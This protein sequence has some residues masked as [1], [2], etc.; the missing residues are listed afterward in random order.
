[1]NTIPKLT[2]IPGLTP[3]TSRFLDALKAKGFK[4]DIL[5]DYASRLVN[6]TDNSVYQILPQAVVA[7]KSSS[8]VELLTS[9]LA[10]KEHRNVTV[11]PRGGG[12]G[13]NG[14]SLTPGIIV[15]LSRHMYR[16][17]ELDKE[18]GWVRVQPGV[19]LDQLNAYLKPHGL[20][21]APSVSPSSRATL[22]GMIATDACGKGSRVYGKT[23]G[24][25]VELTLC[26]PDGSTWVSHELS[27]DELAVQKART[28]RIGDVL[29]VVDDIVT[30]KKELIEKQF[31][32][33]PRF[34]TGYNLAHV[35][36]ENSPFTLNPIVSGAE[37]SLAFVTEAKLRVLPIP[38][39]KSLIAIR[40]AAF[41]DALRAA[42]VL[43]AADPGAIETVDDTIVQLAQQDAIW[44]K[45]EHLLKD[46]G[47]I[48]TAA[49]NLVEFSGTNLDEVTSKMNALVKVL[50]EQLGKPGEAI[51]YTVAPTPTDIA[52]L[53]EL[54]KKGVGLLGNAP[55]ERRPIAFVEDTAVH[56]KD[57]AAFIREFRAILD[58][59]GLTYGMFGHVD[60]GCLHVRPALNTRDV[61]DEKLLREVSDKV[62]AL[63]RRY[64][65]VMWSEHGKGFRSEYSPQFFG[66]EL[67]EDLCK[68]KRAF[69]PHN[70]MNPGKIAVPAGSDAKLVSVDALKRGEFDRM[71]SPKSL[72]RYAT[73][74]NCNG[75]GACFDYAADSV[76]CPS[77]KVTRDRIHS[78]KGRAGVMR[79][80]LRQL[81]EEGFDAAAQ[82][83]GKGDN[84]GLP[85][86]PPSP[87]GK[88]LAIVD[89]TYDFSHEVYA[90]M[91]GCLSCKACA[92]QCPVKVDVPEFK[93][94]FLHLYHKRY[95][96]PA[97]DLFAAALETVVVWMAW[98]PRLV[99]AI[100]SWGWFKSILE[101]VVG[102][103]DAPKL[104]KVN[105]KAGLT[106]RNAPAFDFE[107]LERL[108]D[109]E[110]ERSVVLIQ[111]TFHA[112]YDTH[113][114]LAAYDLMKKLGFT[115]YVAP[116]RPSGK[117]LH[118][119][120]FLDA[121]R[122]TAL[123]NIEF[124]RK[125]AATNVPMVCIDPAVTLCFRDEYAHVVKE[126]LGYRVHL[127]QEWLSERGE[128]INQFLVSQGERSRDTLNT[129]TAF[130]YVL[131]GHC[132]ER[133]AAP[134][135]QR[136]WVDLFERFGV[137]LKLESVGCCGMCG[138][139][140]HEAAHQT[141]SRGI[142]AM[143]WERHLPDDP[144]NMNRYLATGYSCRSQ[145][146]RFS[147][148]KRTLKHPVEVMLELASW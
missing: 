71:I 37:G 26:L 60:A 44:D 50:Q 7:P 65:G 10:E 5:T 40:Y 36:K 3:E 91:D 93:S 124:F 15:D 148:S 52:A 22:G 11:S 88:D 127:F 117:A 141:E 146:K 68:I 1:M 111:D 108:S 18:A 104:S 51:G 101:H 28:D 84:V 77:S 27:E 23:S 6:A 81:S 30:Q 73:T 56:P 25:V 74:V 75:N 76:M 21:F 137:Q 135:T 54:R 70:Q 92:T 142:F 48:P 103:V 119:K 62:V 86:P 57:L 97:K 46:E 144:K 72:V 19:V 132:T 116:Y 126:P 55:G 134:A 8:D 147:A 80:W 61:A 87:L 38:P 67:F 128:V 133:T 78:P 64:G 13:T 66:E 139:Y 98:F 122:K 33:I 83:E 96:R 121:F 94:E 129:G 17:L 29:R 90:A 16:I 106:A 131:M 110:R 42:E 136:Q 118:V 9:L 63:V 45:V 35:R 99:N 53:W 85:K 130:H 59:A 102:I 43:V 41:D 123:G 79:E 138:M 24:H 12:T 39:H 115:V 31:P 120:G 69:D 145:V 112:Y 34:L 113:V 2:K 95:P 14:Q 140:G 125:V 89:P 100:L 20:F 49:I 114:T 105:L 4:G 58:G 109:E 107:R 47:P 143:S 32:K 82:F